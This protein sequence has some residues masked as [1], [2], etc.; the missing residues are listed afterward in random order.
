MRVCAPGGKIGLANWTPGGFIGRLLKLVGTHVPPPA[1]LN[2]PTRWGDRN[3]LEDL[4][5]PVRGIDVTTQHYRFHA[6]SAEAWVAGFA[7]IYGPLLTAFAALGDA[8]RAR[9]EAEI[10]AL[11]N[12]CNVATDGTLVVPSEYVEV[13]VTP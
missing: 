9:L 5:G 8:E 2:P 10:V 11:A 1:G 3:A 4:L 6:R 13:I 7:A 12:E